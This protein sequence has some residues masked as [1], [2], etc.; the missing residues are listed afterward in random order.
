[1]KINKTE[2]VNRPALREKYRGKDFVQMTD[3]LSNQPLN[4]NDTIL[5]KD[6]ENIGEML[7]IETRPHA[8]YSH[9]KK[10]LFRSQKFYYRVV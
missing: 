10:K 4:E 9:E 8:N 5:L 3:N 2:R 6:I 1:M 7:I